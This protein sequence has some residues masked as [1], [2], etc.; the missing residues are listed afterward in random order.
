MSVSPS[1][2]VVLS[3]EDF[4][5]VI[6]HI[7]GAEEFREKRKKELLEPKNEL[8]KKIRDSN[9]ILYPSKDHLGHFCRCIFANE[10]RNSKL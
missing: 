5:V 8:K 2:L 9:S 7:N 1:L 3:C 10:C 4:S 6:E